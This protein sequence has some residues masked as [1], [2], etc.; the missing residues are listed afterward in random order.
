M[1][2]P[3]TKKKNLKPQNMGPTPFSLVIFQ[4]GIVSHKRKKNPKPQNLGST[5]RVLTKH[6]SDKSRLKM[7][8]L[9]TF[10]NVHKDVF[11]F[12]YFIFSKT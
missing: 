11:S 5:G 8:L 9:L 6:L 2:L 12:S 4:C 3:P 7:H 1:G 10:F